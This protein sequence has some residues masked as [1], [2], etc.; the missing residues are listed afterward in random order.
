MCRS[1]FREGDSTS[2]SVSTK[3]ITFAANEDEDEE[4]TPPPPLLLVD[5]VCCSQGGRT[6]STP[7]STLSAACTK[8][9]KTIMICSASMGTWAS[10]SHSFIS[11]SEAGR[12]GRLK[13]R[14]MAQ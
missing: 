1:F 14:L 7:A 9:R 13:C 3:A 4:S 10:S 2:P 12:E 8:G 5:C 6:T 11:L